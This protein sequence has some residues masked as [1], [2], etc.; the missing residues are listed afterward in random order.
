[1]SSAILLIAFAKIKAQISCTVLN[2]N[3]VADQ[4]LCLCY[5]DNKISLLPKSKILKPLAIFCG[6]TALVCVRPAQKPQSRFSRD[7]A[8]IVLYK[9][10]LPFELQ[11]VP[12]VQRTKINGYFILNNNEKLIR[13]S[14]FY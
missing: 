3:H 6:C 14:C 7:A 12:I 1:M 11:T 5:I 13:L 4:H 10:S 8:H 2:L 9:I